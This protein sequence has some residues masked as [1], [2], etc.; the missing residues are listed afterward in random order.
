M[1]LLGPALVLA[2]ALA[3]A[4]AETNT[5]AVV[6][7]RRSGST[8]LTALLA[9]MGGNDTAFPVIEPYFEIM[10]SFLAVYGKEAYVSDELS[11][12]GAW[13]SAKLGQPRARVDANVG[14]AQVSFLPPA[15]FLDCSFIS[16]YQYIRSAYWHFACD[17]IPWIVHNATLWTACQTPSAPEYAQILI[18]EIKQRCT[19]SS[20][21]IAKLL[22]LPFVFRYSRNDPSNLF[23]AATKIIYLVRD[24]RDVFR[25]MVS[26]FNFE[27]DRESLSNL[28]LDICQEMD[29]SK[30][31]LA[32][33]YASQTRLVK[34]ERLRDQFNATL[35]DIV[36]FVG[37][38]LTPELLDKAHELSRRTFAPFRRFANSS[39]GADTS[40]AAL[41][42]VMLA[43]PI[44]IAVMDEHSYR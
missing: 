36:E 9:L 10:R 3:M 23:S 12:S 2:F 39:G 43:H 26:S 44:C 17:N 28:A 19:A 27:P 4:T 18:P 34:Y 5:A 30:R 6:A 21:R 15:T 35:A 13:M 20:F 40:R 1:Q 11:P 32:A 22:R 25:S 8:W 42:F 7:F 33:H 37:L 29:G 41:E 14:L 24:P 16:D 31:I 38:S